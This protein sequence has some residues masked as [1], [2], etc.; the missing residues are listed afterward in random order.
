MM[1]Q[2]ESRPYLEQ[3]KIKEYLKETRKKK[4]KKNTNNVLV[5]FITSTLFIQQKTIKQKEL[6]IKQKYNS[7]FFLSFFPSLFEI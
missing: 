1:G 3:Q 6:Q 5:L 4:K 7:F 2:E